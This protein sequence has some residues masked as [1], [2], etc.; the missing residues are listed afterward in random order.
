MEA[1]STRAHAIKRYL[2]KPPKGATTLHL[3]AAANGTETVNELAQWPIDDMRPELAN[4][5]V[6]ILDDHARELNAA[7][8][9]ALKCRNAAGEFF[10]P[11]KSIHRVNP[12]ALVGGESLASTS[13]QLTGDY[14]SQAQQAQKHLEVMTKLHL[15]SIRDLFQLQRQAQEHTMEL[16]DSLAQRLVESERRE[17]KATERAAEVEDIL[18]SV[19]NQSPEDAATTASQEAI[20][21]T[22][23][24]YMPLIVQA[25]M[26]ALGGPA[27][28]ASSPAA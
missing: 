20:G 25:V 7:I 4:E 24:P 11:V 5:V 17:A 21:K 19:Q 10:G 18:V 13:L 14:T 3:L 12:N 1:E 23:E 9:G 27:P 2:S 26:R 28:A 6:E 22:L 16:C 8:I 15:T